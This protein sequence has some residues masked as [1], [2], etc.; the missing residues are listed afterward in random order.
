MYHHLIRLTSSCSRTHFYEN[1]KYEFCYL[2]EYLILALQSI[3][4][5]I[6]DEENGWADLQINDDEL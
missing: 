4:L 5:G 3:A 1:D 6:K 2:H